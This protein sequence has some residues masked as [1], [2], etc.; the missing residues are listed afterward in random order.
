MN[1]QVQR[2]RVW[3]AQRSERA[4]VMNTIAIRRLAGV[5][6]L[7]ALGMLAPCQDGVAA[8]GFSDP[9]PL[10]AN[11]GTDSGADLNPQVTTDG[12]GNWVA[13]WDSTDDPGPIGPDADVL[14]SRSTDNG[15][16]WAAP[17]TL[18][19]NA[20]TD[21]GHDTFPQVATD[22]AGNWV[23]VWD[24]RDSLGGTIGT[25]YD[26]VTSRSTDNG[27]TWTA[28][29]PLNTNAA[30]DSGDDAYP[31]VTT[32]GAGNWVAVWRSS[33]TLGGTIG[34]DVDVLVSRST[35]NGATW[36]APAALN[37]N[38]ATDSGSDG[39][40]QVTTDGAGHW[41]AA[42]QSTDTLG[43]TIGADYDIL[44]SR[45]TDNGATWTAPAPLNTNAATDSGHDENPQLTTDGVDNWVAVW[46]SS[47]DLGGT[48]GALDADVLVSRST[49]NG[50]TWTAPAPLNTNAATDSESESGIQVTTDRA[51]N[52]VAVWHCYDSLGGTIGTDVDIIFSRS[53][54]GAAHAVALDPVVSPINADTQTLRGRSNPD[55]LVGAVVGQA[56][57]TADTDEDGL[58]DTWETSN[59]G[60]LI[61]GPDDDFDSDGYRNLLEFIGGSDPTLAGGT[62][63][64]YSQQLT[65]GARW[66]AITVPLAEDAPN[67]FSIVASYAGQD[68]SS[69]VV[70]TIIEDSTAPV[71][72]TVGA[73]APF[74]NAD[75]VT[76]SGTAEAD[77]LVTVSGGLLP[78]YQQLTGGGTN[79]SIQVNLIQEG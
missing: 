66:F 41:V 56:T 5:L 61:E 68:S 37:T 34:M 40:P 38:A 7:A 70:V 3:F 4:L 23:G 79:Y 74:I 39:N 15:A 59:F 28:P 77:A 29:A 57:I 22:G 45:S 31:Q 63:T 65:G 49:D 73:L 72:P 24:C 17:A 52:W 16:T 64:V 9:A 20:V 14:V 25:D 10:N 60:D 71:Q 53:Y 48:I 19:T 35:D 62:P 42:W 78:E 43:G 26:I 32:D 58:D 76:V 44:V 2:T 6:L 33:D 51:G 12:A 55:T 18:N 36:T 21:S 47:D 69:P 67:T 13:V 1:A 75:S 8:L 54:L 11:A 27:A 46:R 50:A 30:T